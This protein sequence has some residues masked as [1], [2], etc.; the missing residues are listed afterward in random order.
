MK[1]RRGHG[2]GSI[3]KRDDGRWEC[4]ISLPRGEDGRRRRKFLYGLTQADV[5]QKKKDLLTGSDEQMLSTSTPTV[6]AFL[7]DWHA[8]LSPKWKPKTRYSYQEAIDLYL[9]PA[10]GH[11]RLE[12][13]T[14]VVVQRWLT[15]HQQ[16]HGARRRI[17]LA[18]AVLRSALS[19]A[20]KLQLVT[21]NAAKLVV[22]PK[23]TTRPIVTLDLEQGKAFLQVAATHRL[24]P[25]FSVGLA[26]GLRLG[27]ACG[28][29][30]S[31]DCDGLT[32]G[33]IEIR[34][35]LQLLRIKGQKGRLVVQ[36]L[37]TEKSR[38]T[39]E[40]PAAA[41]DLLQAHRTRQLRERLKAGAT[42][43]DSGLVFVTLG[44]G[45]KLRGGAVEERRA[46]GP[47]HPRNVLRCLHS[48]L[49]SAGLP[50]MRFHELR[51]SAASILLATGTPLV[52]VSQLLGHS[53]IRI[54]SDLYGHLQKQTAARAASAMQS[55]IFA[56]GSKA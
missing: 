24:G 21:V 29:R 3:R 52:E 28:L 34:Q 51:H 2:E 54:T 8:T 53:G 41:R 42:W 6:A 4:V 43:H 55:G 50:R 5:V 20:Q 17:T 45:K 25:L 48:L 47:L 31:P 1:G 7:R 36:E 15:A 38:R 10:F 49:K 9:V 23:P 56:G 46:G 19:H 22:V 14:P 11:L 18:H 13:L 44:R 33:L 27:E 32:S 30:W 39:L 12:R 40:L 37:K 26:C 16:Q 35:Q